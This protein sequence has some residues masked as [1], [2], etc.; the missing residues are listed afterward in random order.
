MTMMSLVY[1][2]TMPSYGADYSMVDPSELHQIEKPRAVEAHSRAMEALPWGCR[3]SKYS[4][5]GSQLSLE[6][7]LGQWLQ[8]YIT[9][10]RR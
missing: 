7:S 6:G 2:M 5:M 4:H 10:K 3:G 1:S 9:L 8:I